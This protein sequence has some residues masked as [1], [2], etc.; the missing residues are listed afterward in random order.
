M[1]GEA[2]LSQE[3]CYVSNRDMK[4]VSVVIP[5]YNRAATLPRAIKSVLSQDYIN[6]ELIIVD[7][8]STDETAEVLS[9][10]EDPRIRIIVHEKNKGFA[11]ALNTGA[12]AARGDFIAFQD[13]DDEWLDGKL[14][15]QMQEFSEAPDDCVCVYCMKIVYGRNPDYVRGKRR[16]V[17]VPG[18][19]MNEVSGDL[20]FVLDRKNLVSTQTIVCTKEAFLRVNGF[21]ERLYNSVDWDFV[22]R[23]ATL[24]SFAFVDEPLVNTYIQKDSISTLS[25][26]APYSQLIIINKLKRRG[27]P[28]TVQAASWARLGY[29]LGKLGYPQRGDILLRAS[30]AARPTTLKTWGRFV[31]N[32]LRRLRPHG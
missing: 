24:G 10:F 3:E 27:V 28:A 21:D 13:S 23:L 25:R 18:P 1:S 7:D 19:D 31:V 5:T 6:L 4:F 22:S 17:C 2:D 12:H 30:L 15:R 32:R 8:A 14:S 29:T 26:K 16:V 11:G 9:R 20:R